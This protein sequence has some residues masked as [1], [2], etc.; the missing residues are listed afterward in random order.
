MLNNMYIHMVHMAPIGPIYA[1][2]TGPK[3][4]VICH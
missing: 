1:P 4:A 2:Q 3:L